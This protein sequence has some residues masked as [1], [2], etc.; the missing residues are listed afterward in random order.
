MKG[1]G[2]FASTVLSVYA[3]VNPT[4][5]LS[6]HVND[7]LLGLSEVDEKFLLSVTSNSFFIDLSVAFERPSI[8]QIRLH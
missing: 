4:I 2:F 8:E 7:G 1:F 5:D 3:S 6:E